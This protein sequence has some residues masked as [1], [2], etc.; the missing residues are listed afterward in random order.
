MVFRISESSFT[1][2]LQNIFSLDNPNTNQ[3]KFW[4]NLI[5]FTAYRCQ[6]E[7]TDI[8]NSQTFYNWLISNTDLKYHKKQFYVHFSRSLMSIWF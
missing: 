2:Y 1:D 4:S 6:L 3:F 5:H 7:S 8:E